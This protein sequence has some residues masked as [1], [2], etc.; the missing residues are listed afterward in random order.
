MEVLTKIETRA[1]KELKTLIQDALDSNKL[2]SIEADHH[3]IV[4]IWGIPLLADERTDVILLKFLRARDF[5]VK[6]AF[7]MIKNTLQWRKEFEVDALLK[8]DLGNDYDKVVFIHGVDKHDHPVC[9]NVFGEF[10]NKELYQNT[11]SDAEKRNKFL[12]WLIQF[13]E[14]TIR[15]FDFTPKGIIPLLLSMIW[16]IL[17]GMESGKYTKL[18]ISFLR[19]C[20]I[21]TLNLQSNR[22]RIELQ[23]SG[24]ELECTLNRELCI[25]TSWWYMIF[26]WIFLTVFAPGSKNKFVFATPSKTTETLFK[27]ISPEHV[28]V[29]FGG[30]SNE[31][32]I[33]VP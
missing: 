20:R 6:D 23:R 21:T 26:N 4:S 11:L 1:L 16:E 31:R 33:W 15:T 3:G 8:E 13:T 14:K 27:Y 7:I 18:L 25:N 2:T 10:H 30:H 29:Q 9:Y 19:F 12:R 28:P 5:R 24:V 32:P 17:L 22:M